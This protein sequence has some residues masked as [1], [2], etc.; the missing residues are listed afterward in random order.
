MNNIIKKITAAALSVAIFALIGSN[1]RIVNADSY[2]PNIVAFVTSLYSDCLNRQ[3]DPVGLDDWC[4]RLTTGQITGKQC[5]YGFFYSPEFIA[6]ANMISDSELIEAYYRVFLN[7]TSDPAGKAYWQ[8]MISNTNND[9]SIL[10]TGFADSTEFAQKCNSYG[11]TV[12]GHVNVPITNR[13]SQSSIPANHTHTWT[14][15]YMEE[16]TGG[17]INHGTPAHRCRCGWVG[18]DIGRHQDETELADP[19][20][21]YLHSG[22]S[23]AVVDGYDEWIFSTYS[24]TVCSVCGYVQ[25]NWVN[26]GES[27]RERHYYDDHGYRDQQIF[28]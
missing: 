8:Q 14:T 18:I 7:R 27:R 4:N 9:V 21:A 17:S 2:N 6:K 24:R 22:W 12:G 10:F 16:Q 15:E 1:F 25:D 26:I 5:A 23:G 11:I 20:H 28:E 13:S 19:S 3:P